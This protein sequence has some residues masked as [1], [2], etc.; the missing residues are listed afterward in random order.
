MLDRCKIYTILY[1]YR[2]FNSSWTIIRYVTKYF[3]IQAR[4]QLAVFDSRGPRSAVAHSNG[5]L[6]HTSQ[7]LFLNPHIHIFVHTLLHFY[8]LPAPIFLQLYQVKCQIFYLMLI[9]NFSW[10]N[11]IGAVNIITLIKYKQI[12]KLRAYH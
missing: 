6:S 5:W 9:S 1:C 8:N 4:Y 11:E 10:R 2:E 3:K 12:L 7:P